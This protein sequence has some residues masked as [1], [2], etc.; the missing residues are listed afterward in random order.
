MVNLLLLQLAAM[1]NKHRR[2]VE[3]F[4]VIP[5]IYPSLIPALKAAKP[6]RL[7]LHPIKPRLPRPPK[8]FLSI[9]AALP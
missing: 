2:G 8:N 3:Q 9:R 1:H 7:L 5:L 6:P 4:I